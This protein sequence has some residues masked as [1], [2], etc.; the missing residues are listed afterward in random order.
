[1]FSGVNE[2]LHSSLYVCI[3]FIST[4][5]ETR[6]NKIPDNSYAGQCKGVEGGCLVTSFK[7]TYQQ[8]LSTNSYNF[9]LARFG[10]IILVGIFVAAQDERKGISQQSYG[11]PPQLFISLPKLKD[12]PGELGRIKDVQ[13]PVDIL[14]IAVKDI[15]FLSCF[16]YLRDPARI[17]DHASVGYVYTGHMGE[18]KEKK[19]KV[20]LVKCFKGGA[21]PGGSLATVRN[22]VPILRPKA[23]FS[24]GICSGLNR[25]KSKLG[26]VVVSAKLITSSH[27]PPAKKYMADLLRHA[28][29]GWQAPLQNPQKREVRVHCDGVFVSCLEVTDKLVQ[30]CPEAIA[31]ESEGEGET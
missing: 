29:D 28:G 18:H 15:E 31:A 10:V 16:Y 24:V 23:V 17:Y 3:Y 22:A 26:D 19:L 5:N 9:K 8:S 21:V 25:N 12:L 7:K 4:N 14:L 11:D 1:M 2:V 27:R 20:A 13:L 30:H 6:R